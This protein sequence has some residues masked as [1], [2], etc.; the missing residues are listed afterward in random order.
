MN[1]NW[2]EMAEEADAVEIAK[3]IGMKIYPKGRN[4]FILCPGHEKRLGKPDVNPTNAVIT[5]EGYYCF[6]C[7]C[8][9]KTPDMIME[10]LGC[11]IKDA[12]KIIADLLGGEELYLDQFPSEKGLTLTE[13]EIKALSLETAVN[14]D[15][16]FSDVAK[17]APKIAKEALKKRAEEMKQRYLELSETYASEDGAYKL[18]EFADVNISKRNELLDELKKRIRT[19]GDLEKKLNN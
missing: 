14:G 12:F 13:D 17:S 18:Y 7:G 6:S 1:S 3:A 2:K 4:N 16:S 9:V 19:L 10:F 15:L 11:G 5:R 8:F